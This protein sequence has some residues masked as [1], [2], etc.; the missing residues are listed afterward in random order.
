MSEPERLLIAGGGMAAGRLLTALAQRGYAGRITVASAE[1][2][3]GYNRVLLP[4]HL[5]GSH[6]IDAL[7]VLSDGWFAER[8]VVRALGERVVALDPAARQVTLAGGRHLAFDRLVIATGAAVPLPDIPGIDLPGVATLRCLDDVRRLRALTAA[9]GPVVVVGGGLL[10]LETAQ[11]LVDLGL[12]VHVVHR[13]AV[14]LNRQLDPDGADCLRR[15][16]EARGIRFALAGTPVA[17]EGRSR[18]ERIRLDDGRGLAAATVVFAT[19]TR[20]RDELARAAG[21]ACDRGVVV[22]D[23]LETSHAGIFA[24][25]ECARVAGR[26]YA[27]VGPVFRQAEAL[28]DTLSGARGVFVPPAPATRLK[29]SGLDVYAAGSLD[30]GGRTGAVRDIRITD[31][32]RGVYRRLVVRD[33]RLSGAVLVGDAA[34][35]AHIE[36][37]I[38]RDGTALDDDAL[39]RAAFALDA[40]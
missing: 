6:D 30:D 22:S 21:L 11:S 40:A 3:V 19:G 20:P 37:L 4:G 35:S 2:V 9:G 17:L 32:R 5:A 36:S 8:G 39:R 1:H 27:L 7:T 23:R 25:G 29:V 18:V 31:P 10:G 15:G 24:I 14:L 34:G 16:L 26:A 13:H 33:G 38:E 12:E 28:A